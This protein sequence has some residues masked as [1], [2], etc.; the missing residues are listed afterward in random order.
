MTK[1]LFYKQV[2]LL[3]L[4][5][6]FQNLLTALLNIFDQMMVGWLPGGIADDGL[7]AVLLANQIVFI[8]QMI[9]FSLCNTVNIFIAQYTENGN[10]DLIKNR[11]GFT[12]ILI[13]IAAIV[14]TLVCYFA[15]G[16]VIGLFNPNESYRYMAEEFLKFVS[17]SFIPMGLSVGIVFMLRAIKRLGAALI[18][19]VSA[20]ALNF[21]LNY[22]FMFGLF[23]VKPYGLVGA[24]YGTIF[25]RAAEFIA[26]VVVLF[27]RK[28]PL[29]GNI[30]E[31]FRLDK[32]YIKQYFRMF[33][34]ILCNEIFWVLSTTVY[35]FV[36]DK[37][38]NSAVVLASVNIAQSL[39]KIVSVVMIGVGSAIGVVM[40][41]VIGK[42]NRNDVKLYARE[43]LKFGVL[44]GIAVT[45][46]TFGAAFVAPGVF[47]NVSA[48]TAV[49]SK[50]LIML[51]AATAVLRTM[52]FVCVISVL[53]SG[54]D[55]TFCM[56]GETLILWMISVPLVIVTG[57]VFRANVYVVYLVSNICEVLKLVLF[58][59]RIKSGKWIKFAMAEDNES[60]VL[61]GDV[62][63]KN[64]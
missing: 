47:R 35:L 14:C 54:G 25:S 24:A 64:E 36:Y 5:I 57:I 33:V 46:L 62:P 3:A 32:A 16:F 51:Y 2:L 30:K 13:M 20:V 10:T 21:L 7:S 4:P 6:A 39:D 23:G 27:A 41:N 58:T 17:L 42:A 50:Y 44:T 9:I 38:D 34:P 43:A 53:R 12:F 63:S 29:V 19:N 60:S 37:L 52:S 59:L 40:G 1:K 11:A 61:Q 18:V 8:Y 48:E 56:V 26:I 31:M 22:T 49:M 15:P 28:N 55:T 45:V